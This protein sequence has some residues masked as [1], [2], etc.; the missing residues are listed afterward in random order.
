MSRAGC[1]VLR[2][3]VLVTAILSAADSSLAQQPGHWR[4]FTSTD[5]LRESWVED[6]SP[7]SGGR[8]WI[9]H[10]AVDSLTVYDGYSFR[11]LPSPGTALKLREGPTGQLWALLPSGVRTGDYSGVQLLD[12]DRWTPFPID[13]LRDSGI[14]R[15]QFLPWATDRVLVLTPGAILEFDKARGTAAV[16]RRAADTPLE[17]FTDLAPAADGGAW[18]AGPRGLIHLPNPASAGAAERTVL[19][20]AGSSARSVSRIHDAGRSLYVSIEQVRGWSAAVLEGATWREVGHTNDPTES[21]HAWPGRN[22]DVW[23]AYLTRFGFRLVLQSGACCRR[24]IERIK[25]FSGR[26]NAVE[27]LPDGGFW[28]ATSLGLVRHAPAAWHTPPELVAVE[29]WI[30]A[31]LESSAGTLYALHEDGLLQRGAYGWNLHRVPPGFVVDAGPATNVAELPDGRIVIGATLPSGTIDATLAFDPVRAQFVPIPHPEGRVVRMIGP[32]SGGGAWVV[33]SVDADSRLERYDGRQFVTVV[34]VQ[35]AWLRGGMPRTILELDG[36][37]LLLVPDGT[38]IGW[39]RRG[40]RDV[41]GPSE[42]YPGS[43]SFAA[44]EIAPGR[45]WFGD[46]DSV[47]AFDGRRWETLRTGLQT[48][49]AIVRTRDGSIWVTSGSGLHRFRDGAWSTV[50][51]PEG[52]PDG[53]AHHLLEDRG[54]TIWV[55]TTA[56]LA[57]YTADAD[58][59]PPETML[60]P[61]NPSE[62]PPSGD[63]RIMFSGRDRWAY[64]PAERLLYSWRLDGGSWSPPEARAAVELQGLPAGSHRVEVRAADR[65]W[66]IDPTPATLD[67]TV[68][69][70]WYRESGFLAMGVLAAIALGTA[71]T[72][73]VSRHVRLERLVGERTTALAS[74]NAQLRAELADRRRVEAERTVLEGQLH[75]AQKLEAVGRLAGGIVHDFN[76]LLTVINGFAEFVQEEAGGSAPVRSA[77]GEISRATERAAALTRQLMAFS[78][79]QIVEPKPLDINQV[80][81]DIERMLRRLIGEDIALTCV[82]GADLWPVLADRGQIEQ[83]I[84]NL[85]VNA[86]DAMPSGGRLTIETANVELDEAFVRIHAGTAGGA[87][88]RLTVADTGVGMDDETRSRIFD[89]FFTTKTR[90]KGS[91]LGLATVYGIVVQADGHIWVDSEPGQGTVFTIYLPRTTAPRIEEHPGGTTAEAPSGSERILVVEDDESV[92]KVAVMVLQHLGY[93]VDDVASG[94]AALERLGRPNGGPDLL[95]TDIVLTGISGPELAARAREVHP[96]LPVLF[97][98]G[99][100]DAAVL[101]D[102]P[103]AGGP[104]F[105]QKPFTAKGLGRKI[106]DVLDAAD[107]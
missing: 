41:I 86:R 24:T 16:V 87:H 12:S 32:A 103:L 52:M 73:F 31:L 11:R 80:I 68:L 72:L 44:L 105:I 62:A 60:G 36:G 6:V 100:A 43:G 84:V 106:R 3:L 20:P 102:A 50:A 14:T 33:T 98:S 37:D 35:G 54:G 91:G 64:S 93:T 22:Q 55:S 82:A 30:G 78:R 58:R 5:G 39:V 53:S 63:I 25:A 15:S 38:G 29:G 47:I 21:I 61:G 49:R 51:A 56:G 70:P 90:D 85:A 88:V 71:I 42:G 34:S 26:L 75:Q 94:E 79:H 95:L 10:G 89:P 92:R 18:I 9:A 104:N 2:G 65:N 27:P 48:V 67:F 40:R 13:A 69:R 28:L 1:A 4:I 81:A 101:R 99:Y 107:A 59:D 97:M 19:L 83:V 74:A 57:S 66:N 96:A 46:R 45:H 8:V 23:T 7:T 17:R 77:I 76:N